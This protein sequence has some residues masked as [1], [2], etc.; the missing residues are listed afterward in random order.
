MARPLSWEQKCKRDAT[1]FLAAYEDMAAPDR[2]AFL[3]AIERRAAQ[4]RSGAAYPASGL[5]VAI[6]LVERP[7]FPDPRRNLRP[8][9]KVIRR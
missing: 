3:E 7:N 8:A 4:C 5:L 2:E 1:R 6:N 9:L